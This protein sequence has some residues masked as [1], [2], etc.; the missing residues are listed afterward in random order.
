MQPCMG[1]G[2]EESSGV[3]YWIRCYTQYDLG[4]GEYL[5]GHTL[6]WEA[7]RPKNVDYNTGGEVGHWTAASCAHFCAAFPGNSGC[8]CALLFTIKCHPPA[9]GPVPPAPEPANL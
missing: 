2:M 8:R 4:R 6:I 3:V 7:K 1:Q 5:S 9:F